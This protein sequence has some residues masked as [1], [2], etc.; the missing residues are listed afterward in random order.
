[1]SEED[2][3]LDDLNDANANEDDLPPLSSML[4]NGYQTERRRKAL[5]GRDSP[6]APPENAALSGDTLYT[7]LKHPHSS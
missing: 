7:L 5:S 3:E 1:M 6:R 4:D 2:G